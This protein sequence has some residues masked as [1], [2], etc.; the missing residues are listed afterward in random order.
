MDPALV[1]HYFGNKRALFVAA[2]SLPIDPKQIVQMLVEGDRGALGERIA[3]LFFS[4]WEAGDTSPF[5]ALIRSATSHDDAV[6]MVRELVSKEIIGPVA[7][8][9]GIPDAELRANLVATHMVGMVMLRYIIKLEPLASADP[10]KLIQ[11]IV[12]SLQR[13]LA[14]DIW[15]TEMSPP[16]SSAQ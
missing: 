9:M 15:N 13:Y 3:R 8:H 1:H 14:D 4:I 2:T 12:P 6:R 7:A 10:E 16:R 11:A 5:I